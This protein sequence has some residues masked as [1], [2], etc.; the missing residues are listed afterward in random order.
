MDFVAADDV[1]WL[2]DT[3]FTNLEAGI[4]DLENLAKGPNIVAA[5]ANDFLLYNTTTGALSYDEDGNGAGEAI[6]I[7]SLTGNPAVSAFDFVI[8]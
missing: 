7:A 5:D 3:I 1:I 2:D 4:L 6:Q 8:V